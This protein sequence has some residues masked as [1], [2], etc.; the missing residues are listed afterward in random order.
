MAEEAKENWFPASIGTSFSPA[1][2]SAMEAFVHDVDELLL[3]FDDATATVPVVVLL[4]EARAL[5]T[6]RA[7]ALQDLDRNSIGTL[8]LSGKWEAKLAAGLC[9]GRREGLLLGIVSSISKWWTERVGKKKV[10]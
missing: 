7:E 9:S 4:V 8:G 1:R 6:W 10:V 5:E 2:S 3:D